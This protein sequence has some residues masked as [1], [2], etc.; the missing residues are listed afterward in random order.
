[1]IRWATWGIS[2]LLIATGGGIV[3]YRLDSSSSLA[4]SLPVV[5][6]LAFFG[7]F[8]VANSAL[9]LVAARWGTRIDQGDVQAASDGTT[10][11]ASLSSE[12]LE[13]VITKA[14]TNRSAK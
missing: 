6:W 14:L 3:A 8:F 9:G 11:P 1:M 5:A 4:I 12:I 13:Q 7:G 2:F 10:D